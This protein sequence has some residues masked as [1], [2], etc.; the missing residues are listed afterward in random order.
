MKNK[1]ERERERERWGKKRNKMQISYLSSICMLSFS[2]LILS[3]SLLRFCEILKI[4]K[5]PKSQVFI[6]KNKQ[7]T[8]IHEKKI[9]I[10]TKEPGKEGVHREVYTRQ[11][12]YMCSQTIKSTQLGFAR[13]ETRESNV[14]LPDLLMDV[15]SHIQILV[16]FIVENY[17]ILNRRRRERER[18]REREDILF[19]DLFIEFRSQVS[20]HFFSKKIKKNTSCFPS[21]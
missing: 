10:T 5:I 9:Q 6:I 1:R 21:R 16:S 13:K 14:L 2:F 8:Q 4:L 20:L 12:F 15:T 19:V 7:K 18:E 11:H 17:K 3:I